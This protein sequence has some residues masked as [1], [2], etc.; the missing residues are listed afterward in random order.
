MNFFQLGVSARFTDDFFSN[1]VR[2]SRASLSK[3][4]ARRIVARVQKEGRPGIASGRP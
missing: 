4:E 3:D 1:L 2:S